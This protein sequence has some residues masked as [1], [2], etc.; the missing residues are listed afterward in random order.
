MII[1]KNKL[2]L[3]KLKYFF[4]SAINTN[5]KKECP[6][7]GGNDFKRL[8]S[9]YF[10]TSLLECQNCK[11]NHRHPKDTEFFFNK[12]YQIDYKID[13]SMMTNI[14]SDEEI[15]RKKANNFSSLR[16]YDPYIDACFDG[17]GKDLT[18]IDYGC[19]WGYNV[20]KL[21]NSG[22]D[23]LGYELSV[24]RAKFGEEKLGVSIYT[25]ENKIR[26]ENDLI[27]SSH[28]IEHLPFINKFIDLSKKLLKKEGVFMAYCP[29]GGEGYAKRD[30]AIWHGTW[31]LE[32]PNHLSVEFATQAFKDNPYLVLTG[33]WEFEPSQI[34]NWDGKSQVVSNIQDGKELL[35]IAK[36]NVIL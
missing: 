11:L 22:Y 17:K 34:A 2:N 20:Y 16:A 7:C 23:A 14:P 28:V 6:F 4:R 12:F 25:D 33:D 10:F 13:T 35:I 21:Q 8:D 27:L 18:I 29:N 26:K 15:N 30:P 5:Q 19:S 36:P 9:K 32:H 24:P 3:N 1:N 31:G